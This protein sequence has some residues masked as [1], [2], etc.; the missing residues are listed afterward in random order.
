MATYIREKRDKV[1]NSTRVKKRGRV[2]GVLSASLPLLAQEDHFNL[3]TACLL[4]GHLVVRQ[5]ALGELEHDRRVAVYS[6]E[7]PIELLLQHQLARQAHGV[8]VV[9]ER[10]QPRHGRQ[11]LEGNPQMQ[12]RTEGPQPRAH[13]HPEPPMQ[14]ARDDSPSQRPEPP[15]PIGR[16]Y[17][18]RKANTKKQVRGQV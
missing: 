13:L 3:Y 11:V 1:G 10:L 17:V 9:A 7:R 18:V 5:V 12:V 16:R 6:D 15:P 8:D 2:S 4:F 14:P